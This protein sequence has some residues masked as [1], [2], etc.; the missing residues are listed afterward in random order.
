MNPRGVSHPKPH[1]PV[2]TNPELILDPFPVV[3]RQ[4]L[5]LSWF[6]PSQS[7]PGSSHLASK[8]CGMGEPP[9]PNL[10]AF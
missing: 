2:Q 10:E 7:K 3:K 4:V 8:A 9:A 6:L 1:R 5:F